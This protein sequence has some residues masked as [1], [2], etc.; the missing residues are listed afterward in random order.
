MATTRENNVLP[1][2]M[3]SKNESS[4]APSKTLSWADRVEHSTPSLSPEY[5]LCTDGGQSPSISPL[6]E[7]HLNLY[8][9]ARYFI[10]KTKETFSNVSPFLI[11][12]AI[13]GTVGTVKTIQKMLSGDLFLRSFIF[14]PC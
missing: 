12:K 7:H 6:G 3:E 10:M 4:L 13:S 2:P 9:S 1:P 14:D 8:E 5:S 11:E